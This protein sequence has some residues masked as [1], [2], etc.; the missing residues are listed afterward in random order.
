MPVPKLK[1]F[2]ESARPRDCSGSASGG[3]VF[4]KVFSQIYDSSI[5]ENPSA[6]F[7]FMDLLVLADRNGVV[8]MTHEAIARRTN[9]PVETIRKTILELEGPDARSR[10]PDCNGARLRRLDDHR[11]WGWM[12]VNYDYFRAIA[13]EEQRREKTLSRVHK[14]RGV[15][16]SK[17]KPVTHCNALKRKAQKCN[18]S[19][20]A[21]P[22]SFKALCT[23]K[24]AEDFCESIQLPRSD[25]EAMFLHWE[26][27]QWRDVKDWKATIRK[28]KS[29]NYMPSQKQ[30]GKVAME[31]PKEHIKWK[32]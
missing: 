24:E 27:K 32:N 6:R 1:P 18:D 14:F 29:F 17:S 3:L 9:R 8:D 10:T 25:G 16:S 15:K 11:D 12:I 22:S 13:S 19:P 5:V 7:T 23:Q 28:W 30:R 31:K 26:E 21:S 4:A 2:M 20:S